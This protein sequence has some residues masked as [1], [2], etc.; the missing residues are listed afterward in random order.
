MHSGKIRYVESAVEFENY[1]ARLKSVPCPHCRTVGS[2][3]RHGYL[4]GYG[5]EGSEKAQRGWRIFCNNR[6]RRKGCGRTHSILLAQHLRRRVVRAES[7]WKFLEGV[8]SGMSLKA[9]WEK[10]GSLFCVECGY[11]LWE[12]FVEAQHRIRTELCRIEVPAVSDLRSPF[13]QTIQHLSDIFTKA[14]C[15]VSAFQLRFQKSF[16]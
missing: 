1:R 6:H 3:I 11:R 9:S 8:L 13:F 12:S 4:R 2:L 14:A 16:L 10:V 5:E 7:L 15:P